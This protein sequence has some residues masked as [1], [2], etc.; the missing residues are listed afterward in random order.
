MTTFTPLQSLTGGAMIGLAAVML[1]ALHGRIAGITGILAGLLP[2]AQAPD[3][4]WRAAFLAG[5]VLAPLVYSAASGTVVPLQVAGSPALL[6]VA[7][8]IVGVGV[9]YA[10][11]CT[12]GHGVC[13]LARLSPRSLAAMVT[14]MATAGLTVFLVR[15]VI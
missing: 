1:M 13:G 11:G 14:F 2:P 9:T 15:H 5:M 8:V 7:G 4:V 3:W 6:L 12:S 10:S